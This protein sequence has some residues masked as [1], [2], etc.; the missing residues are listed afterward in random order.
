MTGGFT[1]VRNAKTRQAVRESDPK[2]MPRFDP[3]HTTSIFA[4]IQSKIET[5][6]VLGQRPLKQV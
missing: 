2:L 6:E 4:P 5:G 3:R 1:P